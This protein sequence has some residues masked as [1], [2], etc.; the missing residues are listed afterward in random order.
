[1]TTGVTVENDLL[2]IFFKG[3][4]PHLDHQIEF[5][6]IST[7]NVVR[8]IN[9]THRIGTPWI[10]DQFGPHLEK[11]FVLELGHRPTRN[12][13]MFSMMVLKNFVFRP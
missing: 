8:G 13:S 11:Q 3:N 9:G 2:I 6:T 7:N 4:Y 5:Y 10:S 12:G 1:M